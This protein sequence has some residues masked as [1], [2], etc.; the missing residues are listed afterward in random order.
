MES[1]GDGYFQCLV[2]TAVAG[3]AYGFLLDHSLRVLPD[4]RSRYQPEGV[5]GLSVLVDPRGWMWQDSAWSGIRLRDCVF[6]EMHLGC[7]T[8]EGTFAAA[9]AHLDRL[10]SLGVTMIELMPL[11]QCS[12]RWNW[13]YDGV[14]LYAVNASYGAPDD[15]RAFVQACHQRGLGVI[16]DVVYNHLGPEGNHLPAFGPYHSS[17]HQTPWGPGLNFDGKNSAEVRRFVIEN[18]LMWLQEY[19][20]DGLR[21]DATRDMVDASPVHILQELNQCVKA[22]AELRGRPFYLFAENNLYAET[23]TRDV[24]DSGYGMDGQW[25]DDVGHCLLTALDQPGNYGGRHYAGFEDMEAV[26]RQGF[27]YEQNPDGKPGKKLKSASQAPLERLVVSLQNHDKVGNDPRGRRVTTLS[28]CA[29][30]VAAVAIP[31]LYPGMPLM[32]MGEEWGSECPFYFFV[33]FDSEKLRNM[34]EAGRAREYAAR[35]WNGAMSPISADAFYQSRL[36]ETGRKQNV[37]DW[38]QQLLSIRRRWLEEGLLQ[39]QCLQVEVNPRL[40]LICLWYESGG[41][42]RSVVSRICREV[43]EKTVV[44]GVSAVLAASEEVELVD[45]ATVVLPAPACLVVEGRITYRGISA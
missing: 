32:F 36:R 33:D 1:L 40:G 24:S 43:S 8:T 38:Y 18:A 3:D 22:E 10:K 31:L 21:L 13:G 19:H 23:L 14:G 12:G 29:T 2:E 44:N 28:D 25:S 11:A 4:P 7:L 20:V 16:V 15:L 35:D 34:V 6:Y 9:M 41:Q 30:Q 17:T 42:A 45:K 37:W 39:A 27:L 5:D 26:L